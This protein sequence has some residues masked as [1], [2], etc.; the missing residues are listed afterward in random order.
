[1]STLVV[2]IA[3]LAG[4]PAAVLRAPGGR[5]TQVAD[6]DVR[7]LSLEQQASW[8]AYLLGAARLGDALN[9]QMEREAGLSLSEYEVL[10]RLSEAHGRS[11]RMSDLA[12]SLFHSRSRLTHTVRRLEARGLVERQD[13]PEDRRGVYCAITD[14]GFRH[15]ASSAPGHVRAVRE[16]LVDRLTDDE[17]RNLGVAMGKVAPVET[18]DDGIPL[19]SRFA[20]DVGDEQSGD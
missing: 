10:A 16:Q 17:L 2:C 3:D 12:A 19:G 5:D 1:M 4:T 13:C 14:A 8:R 6:D 11:V 15:L 20:D 9:R 7:W 18:P